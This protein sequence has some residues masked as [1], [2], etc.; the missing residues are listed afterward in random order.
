MR[1]FLFWI[2]MLLFSLFLFVFC[3][4]G[5]GFILNI[6]FGIPLWIGSLI[7]ICI[8]VIFV[9]LMMIIATNE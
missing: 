3:S 2:L 6:L 1:L 7:T 8:L 5:G 9:M 4:I